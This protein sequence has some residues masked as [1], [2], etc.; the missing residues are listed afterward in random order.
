MKK[1]SIAKGRRLKYG[2]GSEKVVRRR[3]A[4][5]R[6]ATV[7]YPCIRHQGLGW[8]GM[9]QANLLNSAL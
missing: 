5:V 2:S 4:F 8:A 7:S 9:T 1:L 6:M 3:Q